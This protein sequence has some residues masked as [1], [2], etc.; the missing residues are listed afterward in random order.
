VQQ[1]EDTKAVIRV[2]SIWSTG[3]MRHR[4]PAGANSN[5]M[6]AT[7]KIEVI[8]ICD[9]CSHILLAPT[10]YTVQHSNRRRN[11]KTESKR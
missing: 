9:L 4:R 10:R 11:N 5:T 6:T 3:I 7:D 8:G 2:L 1:V